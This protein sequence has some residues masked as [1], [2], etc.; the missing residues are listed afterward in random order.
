MKI[1]TITVLVLVASINI[2]GCNESDIQKSL[3]STASTTSLENKKSRSAI[4]VPDPVID[5]AYNENDTIKSISS[6]NSKATV[7]SIIDK[8]WTI[9]EVSNNESIEKPFS[10]NFIAK[11]YSD[12]ELISLLPSHGFYTFVLTVT[13][14]DSI[15]NSSYELVYLENKR[16]QKKYGWIAK[17]SIKRLISSLE[18]GWAGTVARKFI[19]HNDIKYGIIPKLRKLSKQTEIYGEQVVGLLITGFMEAGMSYR[20]ARWVSEKIVAIVL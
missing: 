13:N 5:I 3:S 11:T 2:I 7:G 15:S 1:K 8:Y 14:S 9:Y 18:N 10:Y 12:E 20:Y 17:K 19:S 4:G 6:G 16:I